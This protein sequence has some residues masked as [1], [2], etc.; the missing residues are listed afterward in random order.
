M[1]S[2]PGMGSLREF[3][4][5]LSTVEYKKR[6][7]AAMASATRT[8]QEFKSHLPRSSLTLNPQL[9][10]FASPE[11]S[12]LS[13]ST[14]LGPALAE[15]HDRFYT[16]KSRDGLRTQPK[17]TIHMQTKGTHLSLIICASNCQH[18]KPETCVLA[19]KPYEWLSM[20]QQES[21]K[22]IGAPS[23]CTCICIRFRIQTSLASKHFEPRTC[24]AAWEIDAI[25]EHI[26][27]PCHDS[28]K[29]LN[30]LDFKMKLVTQAWILNF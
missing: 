20:V 13:R 9:F 2:P 3:Q 29:V 6:D 10:E 8:I 1:V 4:A 18:F 19:P 26:L 21:R 22:Q 24:I 25:E 7:L 30:T 27:Q 12:T 23:I 11:D 17:N 14:S 28:R 15:T 16:H 5:A